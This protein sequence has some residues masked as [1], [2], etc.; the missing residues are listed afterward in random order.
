MAADVADG[1][2]LFASLGV[3]DVD[4]VADIVFGVHAGGGIQV[5]LVLVVSACKDQHVLDGSTHL[6]P[7]LDWGGPGLGKFFEAW[8]RATENLPQH[9]RRIP[10]GNIERVD[11]VTAAAHGEIGVDK[12]ARV[13]PGGGTGGWIAIDD[14]VVVGIVNP[15][16]RCTVHAIQAGFA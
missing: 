8:R 6:D 11:I 9:A 7:G 16:C 4:G 12:L 13:Q 15:D 10:V 14:A 5:I 2:D 3:N 1:P